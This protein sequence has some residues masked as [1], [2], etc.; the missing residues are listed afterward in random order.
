MFSK[1]I[2]LLKSIGFDDK[3]VSVYAAI[4][5]LGS[6]SIR[7]IAEKTGINR[8]TVYD[9]LEALSAKG[10]ISSEKRGSKRKF[11]ADSPEKV[12]EELEKS[13]KSIQLKKRKVQEAMPVLLSFYAKQ[14]GRPTVEYF[15]DDQGIKTIL[16][17]VLETG[18]KLEEKM[19]YVYS[20]RPVRDYLYRLFPEFTREKIKF[21]IKTKVVA[22]GMGGDPKNFKMAERRWLKD[23]APAYFLLY[24]PKI[25]LISVAEDEKP[26]GVV[27]SDEKIAKT[28]KIIF[29][30]LWERLK[31]K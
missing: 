18:R 17:D 8:G 27:V 13:E 5:P 21:G 9:I 26:F 14:G 23:E 20:S 19:T 6:A 16:E 25:A 4:L 3:E 28:Q 1:V 24:G 2:P 31:E 30:S 7:A 10:L 12:L 15:D 11:I 29:E 22:L